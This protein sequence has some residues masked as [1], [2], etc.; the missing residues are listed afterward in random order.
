VK[1]L[2][3]MR[4]INPRIR[5]IARSS[6]VSHVPQQVS[7]RILHPQVAKLRSNNQKRY[8]RLPLGPTLNRQSLD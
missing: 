5:I 6:Q 7:L 4:L 3:F 1:R 8:R 2:P